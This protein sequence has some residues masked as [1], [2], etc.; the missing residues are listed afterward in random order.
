MSKVVGPGEAEQDIRDGL[1]PIINAIANVIGGT[2]SWNRPHENTSS[3]VYIFEWALAI[4]MVVRFDVS[5]CE[6]TGLKQLIK[7]LF[8]LDFSF[9]QC[10]NSLCV[11]CVLIVNI[12]DSAGAN[13]PYTSKSGT[14][15]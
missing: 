10:N 9:D 5:C 8:Y 7:L 4:H 11:K 2:F 3:L 14:E 12:V 15:C 6:L 13:V 1:Y